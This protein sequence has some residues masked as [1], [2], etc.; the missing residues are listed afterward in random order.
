VRFVPARIK[1]AEEHIRWMD[2]HG[3]SIPM[4]LSGAF[5]S[6]RWCYQPLFSRLQHKRYIGAYRDGSAAFWYEITSRTL[7][8][9]THLVRP[10]EELVKKR[11]HLEGRLQLCK[12]HIDSGGF[13]PYSE[14]CQKCVEREGCRRDR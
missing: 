2:D 13:N 3:F 6:H 4:Y 1:E 7:E 10:S 12:V 14:F 5:G 8:L 11:F 9:K